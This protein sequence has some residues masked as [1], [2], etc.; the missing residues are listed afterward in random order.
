MINSTIVTTA[1]IDSPTLVFTSSLDGTAVTVPNPGQ[2]S[3]VT[4]IALCNVLTPNLTDE[5]INSTNV[6][7]YFVSPNKGT[8][9]GVGTL[10][11]SNL[12]V[13]AGETLFFSEERMVLSSGDQIWIGSSAV[14][15]HNAGSFT[16]GVR[17][18]I[19]SVGTT[20]FTLIGA[21]SNTVGVFF[22]ATGIGSGSGTA[23]PCP[24]TAT[25]SSLPV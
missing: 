25:V 8:A 20:N 14:A 24:I 22:T 21:A 2:T 16:V 12:T 7:I 13:P 3:A 15:D 10:V 4:T 5:T 11:V 17:Y 23:R 9:V 19:T 18:E 6:N 1:T